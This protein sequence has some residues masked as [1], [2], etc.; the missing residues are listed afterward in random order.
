MDMPVPSGFYIGIGSPEF[1]CLINSPVISPICTVFIC[2]SSSVGII[3][4][5]SA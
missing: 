2:A 4:E 5:Y 1:Q 3:P